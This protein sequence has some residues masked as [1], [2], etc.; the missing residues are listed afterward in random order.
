MALNSSPSPAKKER[1]R[2]REREN[3]DRLLCYG[4]VIKKK[5]PLTV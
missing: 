3:F 1:E 4:T 2:E 5:V